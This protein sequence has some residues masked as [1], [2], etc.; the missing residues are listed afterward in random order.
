MKE[1]WKQCYLSPRYHVSNL[2]RVRNAE[3]KRI[4][5][6]VITDDGYYMV[7]LSVDTRGK[8]RKLFFNIDILV[9]NT[10]KPTNIKYN[11]PIHIDGNKRNNNIC[12]LQWSN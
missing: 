6:K 11:T 3:D 12:N 10:F 8:I 5:S 4:K 9:L 2:G 1:V 7:G